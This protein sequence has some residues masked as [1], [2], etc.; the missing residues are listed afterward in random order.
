MAEDRRDSQERVAEPQPREDA[1]LGPLAWL[2]APVVAVLMVFCCAGPLLV[3]ALPVT[4]A[5][6]WLGA[7]GYILGAAALILLAVAL[8]W[9][10]RIR[11]SR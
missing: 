11:V 9:R 4:G 7:H 5:G 10:A 1:P 8:I 2:G 3:G 6:A